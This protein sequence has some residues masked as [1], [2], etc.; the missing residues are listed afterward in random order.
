MTLQNI[1]ALLAWP[2]LATRASGSTGISAGTTLDAAAEYSA[3]VFQAVQ[4]MTVSHV[5]HRCGAATGSPTANIRIETID[6][7]TGLSTG[8]LWAANTKVDGVSVT[9]AWNAYALTATATIPKGSIF[10]VKTVF[11]SGTSLRVGEF[12]GFNPQGGN[13]PYED[14]NTSGSPAKSPAFNGVCGMLGLGSSLTNWYNLPAMLPVSNFAHSTFNNTNSAARA[15]RFKVP[16][17]CRVVGMRVH[18]STSVGDFAAVIY[19]DAGNELNGSSTAFEGDINVNS[20]TSATTLILDNT[21]T[22]SPDTWYRAAIVPASSTNCSVGL[23]TLP[24]ADYRTGIPGGVNQHYAVRTSGTWDDS[25]TSILP[26]IDVLIDQL[27]DGAGGLL[28]A[29]GFTGGMQRE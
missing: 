14:R 15:L 21:V 20:V 4:D 18:L 5:G 9:A 22:L 8:T 27:D 3:F 25:Q 1:S 2:G 24:G 13:L 23:L 19:D 29:G 11:A 26:L 7:A 10:A 12:S 6:P 17:K 28:L 16:F